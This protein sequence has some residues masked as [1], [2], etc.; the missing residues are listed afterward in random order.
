MRPLAHGKR[1]HEKNRS[2]PQGELLKHLSGGVPASLGGGQLARLRGGY[3][4]PTESSLRQDARDAQWKALM[5]L[6][7][8]ASSLPAADLNFTAG[9]RAETVSGND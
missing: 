5:A 9:N 8:P 3:Q 2:S 4:S 6:R 1:N 7:I